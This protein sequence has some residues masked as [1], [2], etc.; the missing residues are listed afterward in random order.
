M[1]RKDLEA[2]AANVTYMRGLLAVPLGSAF[3]LAGLGNLQWGPLRHDWVFVLCLAVIAASA[4]AINSYYNRN[5]GRVTTSNR[6]RVRYVL[7]YLF[8]GAAMVGG[9]LLDTWLNPSVSLFAALFAVAAISWY[10]TRV[11]LRAYHVVVWGAL[12]V[13]A[14]LPVWD[15]L[16]DATSVAFLAIGAATIVSGLLDHRT[17]VRGFGAAKDLDV[18]TDRART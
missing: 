14:L 5:Y 7:P 16:D 15:S 9:P 17:L 8:Y 11:Q 6:P 4:L 10:A 13:V 1:Q 3:L 2:A 12:L 18:G